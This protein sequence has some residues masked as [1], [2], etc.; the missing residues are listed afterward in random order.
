MGADFRVEDLF[1]LPGLL[2]KNFQIEGETSKSTPFSQSV[3][4]GLQGTAL[5]VLIFQ[6]PCI[7]L[8]IVSSGSLFSL[9]NARTASSV[10]PQCPF[11]PSLR[12]GSRG[13]CCRSFSNR[14][15]AGARKTGVVCVSECV[16]RLLAEVE[17]NKRNR[18]RNPPQPVARAT[19]TWPNGNGNSNGRGEQVNKGGGVL[20]T[21]R[22]ADGLIPH[23]A[24]WGGT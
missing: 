4:Q 24:T 18:W 13:Q 3:L 8:P 2:W 20:L 10:C 14:W 17:R 23:Q 1:Q 5:S 12:D 9:L 11:S 7:P 22:R 16:T 21:N 6:I 15:C 19:A